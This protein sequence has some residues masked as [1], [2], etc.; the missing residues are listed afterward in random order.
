MGQHNLTPV[1]APLFQSTD[2]NVANTVVERDTDGNSNFNQ[3]IAEDALVSE[4]G[5]FV[6][7]DAKTTNY[8]VLNDD[9][10]L[11]FTLAGDVTA[12]L[13]VA[14]SSENQI[15][16]IKLLSAGAFVLTID[17]NLAET[18]DGDASIYLTNKYESVT[19]HCDG[20]NWHVLDHTVPILSTTKSAAFAVD[21]AANHYVCTEGSAYTITLPNAAEYKGKTLTFLKIDA[22]AFGAVLDG[23]GA[24]NVDGAATKSLASTQ[25][26]VTTILSTGT[27]WYSI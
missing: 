13:P 12:T 25:Y 26:R 7:V 8:T 4:G 10:T 23:E 21:G 5:L 16:V 22:A 17:A 11:V 2:A 20:S 14:A 18:I 27:Q 3:A 1:N 6:D 15:V 9:H 24:E 19:L